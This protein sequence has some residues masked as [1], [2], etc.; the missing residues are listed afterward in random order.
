[1]IQTKREKNTRKNKFYDYNDLIFKSYFRFSKFCLT[2][3]PTLV[4]DENLKWCRQFGFVFFQH[5]FLFANVFVF[6]FLKNCR[7]NATSNEYNVTMFNII[8]NIK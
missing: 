3:K 5:V 1:M 6:T 8:I 7:E 2:R 4:F